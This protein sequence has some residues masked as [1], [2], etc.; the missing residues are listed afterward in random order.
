MTGIISIPVIIGHWQE[1][2]F[3]SFWQTRDLVCE[4]IHAMHSIVSLAANAKKRRYK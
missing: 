4:A 2:A 3:H 1:I